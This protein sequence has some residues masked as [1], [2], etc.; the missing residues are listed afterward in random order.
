[1]VSAVSEAVAA[2]QQVKGGI[3]NVQSQQSILDVAKIEEGVQDI[4]LQTKAPEHQA[5]FE[6]LINGASTADRKAAA[7]EVTEQMLSGGAASFKADGIVDKVKVA[8]E[9]KN[10]EGG[11]LA[12]KALAE[13]KHSAAEAYVVAMLPILMDKYADKSKAIASAAA[14]A[15]TAV[16]THMNPNGVRLVLPMLF[17]AMNQKQK[18][19]TKVGA[20]QQ[21]GALTKIAPAQ[22]KAALPDI[23]PAVGGCF[24]DAK[25]QVKTAAMKTMNQACT[26]VGNRDI[27]KFIPALITAMANPA[28]VS[29]TVH[30]LSATTFVQAVEAP[31][32]S[33]MVPLLVRG[34]RERQTAI[35][36]KSAVIIDN[37]SKLVDN[38]ADAAVFLPRLLPGV[39]DVA[40][41][42]ADPEC[43]SVASKAHATLLKVGADGKVTGIVANEAEVLAVL[44][45][46]VAKVDG[47]VGEVV[48][49][50]VASMMCGLI[51]AS[52][53]KDEQWMEAVV[54]YLS[55]TVSK[56]KAE[57]VALDTL[58][59]FFKEMQE[60]TKVVEEEEEG[61]DLCNCEF[62]L[63]YG[64]KILLNNARLHLKRGKRYGLCGPNGAGKSTLMRSIANGQLDG[65]PPKDE[66][67]T[68]YVEHDIDASESNVP[69]VEYV[70]S[71]PILQDASHPA[72]TQ[73]SEVLGS[74]GFTE[75]MQQSPV[76][77]LSGG[78]KMK[79]ALARA[80]LMKAD[81]M[82]LDEPTNHLDVKNVAWLED[83]LTHLPDVTSMVVSHDSGFL[84]HVCT[85]IIHYENRKLKHYRGNLSEF[86]KR[87]PEAQ[88]YYNLEAAS[89]KFAFPEP[90]FLE[91]IKT[92]DKA[93]LKMARVG[94]TYPNTTRKV[95]EGVSIAVTLNSRVAV[96]GANG[97]GKSTMIKLLTGEL[98]TAEGTVWKHP[99]L[100]VAYVAQHAFHHIEQHLDKTPNDYIAWRYASGEDR[101]AQ[102]KA[103]AQ[104]SA[105][106]QKKMD[107]KVMVDGVKR[108]V[109]KLLARRKLKRSYEYEV[110][111]EGQP[112]S[113]DYTA[114]L[115]RDRLEEM[116]FT[117][118]VNEID[119]KEAARLGLQTRPLTTA[120]IQK[121]LED[122]GIEP[123]FGTHS[124]MRGLS[125][126]QKVKVVLAAAMWNNPHI[127][128]LDEPTNY[129]D[130]ESL[131][132]LAGAIR[133][134]GGGCLMISHNREFT[135]ALCPTQWVVADG[136]LALKG[137]IE[138][139]SKAEKLEWKPQEETVDAFGNVV[140]I[141]APKKKLSNKEKKQRAK[142]RKA[143]RER[144]EDVSDTD[145]DDL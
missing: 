103:S 129:L 110:Q 135:D 50:Y 144:G 126:G 56:D 116:G 23:V 29:E 128:V 132:A 9:H 33:I 44:G 113:S 66:L 55:A 34:L 101:E 92:K 112:S 106:E 15:A 142:V 97:A 39:E 25:P 77:S 108:V 63:A 99:N 71:D 86:V 30:K 93:I 124:R 127:L 68:V 2:P 89:T 95:L 84:D 117:K 125:G 48:V 40:Q 134:Y 17:D 31:A 32:L 49:K 70:Y 24:A 75:A 7:Q 59:H 114:W 100:R 121:H 83:Y 98:E 61:E 139:A 74:V 76:S 12:V 57:K 60:K 45:S 109:S 94:F 143:Q 62:S 96:I 58:S 1:M 78:W 104:I 102:E 16:L 37:M 122:V 80:M 35:K 120:V 85:G 52:Q 136:K 21:L 3:H 54:P 91:G 90:G 130:R 20:L 118:M 27:E 14:E 6:K 64:G 42:V 87:V 145:E 28:E 105:E 38:P 41:N 22:M 88:A 119:S 138:A 26:A 4:D 36:R 111:W 43:R 133:N 18:W 46:A 82:L 107:E 10:A 5:L 137:E 131:G 123:E 47:Q 19:Q 8:A 81:I 67:R 65:F 141:K 115:S 53:Y 51:N 13:T 11:L 140:K 73:V 79:L 69:V 72:H